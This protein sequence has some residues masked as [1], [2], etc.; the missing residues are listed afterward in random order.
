MLSPGRTSARSTGKAEGSSV[1]PAIT[2][3]PYTAPAGRADRLAAQRSRHLAQASYVRG[4]REVQNRDSVVTGD[5]QGLA[6]AI[7]PGPLAVDAP[8]GRPADDHLGG[9]AQVLTQHLVGVAG[10][11]V[12]RAIIELA[13]LG[14][15]ASAQLVGV[16]RWTREHVHVGSASVA[17]GACFEP[18]PRQIELGAPAA[19]PGA[20]IER[21]IRP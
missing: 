3:P 2:P 11:Q 20:A 17:P 15:K 7:G 21:L 8:V 4:A 19:R 5:A 10:E 9:A 1:S 16:R 14:V 6:G 18:G 12:S 13:P